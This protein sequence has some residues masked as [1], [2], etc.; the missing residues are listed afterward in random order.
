MPNTSLRVI[1]RVAAK[2]DCV[3]QV[4]AILIGVVEP[5]RREPGCLSYQL[6][7][8][9]AAPT[10]F[11]FIEEWESAAAE[12]SHFATAHIANALRQLPGLLAAEPDIRRYTVVK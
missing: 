9:Q 10:D 5:T 4:R 8:N 2:A 12:Q 1:A 11:A 6:L 7:Q 3:E